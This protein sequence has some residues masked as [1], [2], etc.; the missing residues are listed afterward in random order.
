M[1]SGSVPLQSY[2]LAKYAVQLPCLICGGGNNVDAELCRYC[3]APL[4]LAHQARD[5]KTPPQLI[6]TIGTADAGKTVYL[7]MLM[8]ILSR[9]TTDLQLLARGAF[10]VSLQQQTIA[11]LSR[12]RFPEKTPNDPDRWNWV[13]CQVR[14]QGRKQPVELIMPDLA[15]EAILEELDHPQTYPVIT[16]F[17]ARCRGVLLL[18]DTARLDAGEEDQDFFAMKIMSFLAEVDRPVPAGKKGRRPAPPPL[19]EVAVVF[20]KADRCAVC[21]EDP[22]LFAR[23]RTPGLWQMCREQFPEHRFF[24]VSVAG[25]CA[26]LWE[27]GARRTI[28]LRIEPRGVV[29]PFRWLVQKLS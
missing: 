1:T 9:H 2:D 17:L 22:D 19:P 11:A 10:S 15:G 16:A 26:E 5:K 23:R 25:A 24:G 6:A 27:G 13:H 3:Q 12:C 28:P 7:G 8:D 21:F 4:A 18:I 29:E 14:Q 20:T